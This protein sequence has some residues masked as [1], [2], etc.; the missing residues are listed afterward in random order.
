METTQKYTIPDEL[1]PFVEK[2]AHIGAFTFSIIKSITDGELDSLVMIIERNVP[3]VFDGMLYFENKDDLIKSELLALYLPDI[4]GKYVEYIQ[5][6]G[7]RGCKGRTEV[8]EK[9]K[10]DY[11]LSCFK[12]E[13]E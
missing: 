1:K 7:T 4:A 8:I 12:H 11:Y 10:I 5:H 6:K 2:K 3:K 13:I 9:D